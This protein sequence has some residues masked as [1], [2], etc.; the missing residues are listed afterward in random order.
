MPYQQMTCQQCSAP[1]R[2]RI[3]SDKPPS[4]FCSRACRDEA[5]RTGVTLTCRQCG[6]SFYRKNYQREWSQER[7]PFCG[8]Q[9]YGSWQREHTRGEASPTWGKESNP[10]GRSSGRWE[11]NRL[12]ALARDGH[13]CVE[14]GTTAPLHVHH[15]V[16]WEAGQA[17]PHA[18]DN[19]VTLCVLHHRREH[20]R[21]AREH[22]A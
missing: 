18:L 2:G 8:M 16:P 10:S 20:A 22:A 19:L 13:R 14:C 7:G 12:A 17:D 9:C 3:R 21:L 6:G 15:V 4:K 11:R 5:R 1:F